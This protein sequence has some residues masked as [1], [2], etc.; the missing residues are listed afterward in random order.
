MFP[1]KEKQ[2]IDLSN[3]EQINLH[4]LFE[5]LIKQNIADKS[6]HSQQVVSTIVDNIKKSTRN[7][8]TNVFLND[9]HYNIVGVT[10]MEKIQYPISNVNYKKMSQK[11]L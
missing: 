3:Q 4:I 1:Y 8:K 9:Y 10:D 5:E 2:N 6:I 11:Q 7:R